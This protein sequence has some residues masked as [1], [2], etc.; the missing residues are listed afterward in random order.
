MNNVPNSDSQQCTESKLSR[1][2]SAHTLT[3]PAR[4]G[5]AH[6]AQAGR[7]MGLCPT[8]SWLV[9]G[10]VA[11]LA[12]C[13]EGLAS[14]VP[15]LAERAVS[16]RPR[17]CRCAPCRSS[18]AISWRAATLYRSALPSY[19]DPKSPPQPRYKSLY[20]DPAPS[21]THCAPCRARALPYRRPPSRIVVKQWS[22]RGLLHRIVVRPCALPPSLAC[23]NTVCCI[24]P[25][26]KKKW[27]VS[28]SM[29]SCIF[30]FTFFFSLCSSY[31]KTTKK[32]IFF[33]VFIGTK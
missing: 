26:T 8:A 12:G 24:V 9:A 23:H 20:R 13:V 17:K 4:T 2:Y 21:H 31:C 14:R 32:I 1:V 25:Q 33:H 5:H 18:G 7:V 19:R 29:F 15:S 22:Y 27:V 3:K 30:F 10:R 16:S 6:Y 28:H 11:G